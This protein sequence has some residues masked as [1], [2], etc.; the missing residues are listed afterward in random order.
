MARCSSTGKQGNQTA[1]RQADREAPVQRG[2]RIMITSRKWFDF[3]HAAALGL[4]LALGW[5]GTSAGQHLSDPLATAS[6]LV[7]DLAAG[8]VATA[9]AR[10]TSEFQDAY[11]LEQFRDQLRNYI[12]LQ[13]DESSRGRTRDFSAVRTC[14]SNSGKPCYQVRIHDGRWTISVRL[15]ADGG[16]WRVSACILQSCGQ[17]RSRHYS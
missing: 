1:R 14:S 4:I 9:Y 2:R 7:D 3:R 10:M 13:D 11:T 5:F 6:A 15:V 16:E 12:L 17:I 8:R